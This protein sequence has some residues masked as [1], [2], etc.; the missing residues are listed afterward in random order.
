MAYISGRG[1]CLSDMDSASML[2]E[3][4]AAHECGGANEGLSACAPLAAGRPV[5]QP[6]RARTASAPI[7]WR[8]AERVREWRFRSSPNDSRFLFAACIVQEVQVVKSDILC[9]FLATTR[10]RC[11]TPKS[12]VHQLVAWQI[13]IMTRQAH[14]SGWPRSPR[15]PRETPVLQMLLH[16]HGQSI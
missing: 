7:S 4:R 12:S 10:N 16:A 3:C 6:R 5:G 14:R 2:D 11:P 8:A 9:I 15:S 1:D 13:L